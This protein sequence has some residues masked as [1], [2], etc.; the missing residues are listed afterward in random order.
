VVAEVNR[1]LAAGR[2]GLGVVAL[3]CQATAL[4]KMRTA[5][6]GVPTL[7]GGVTPAAGISLVVGL[8]CTWALEQEGWRRLVRQRLGT[9][10]FRR[11]DIPPPP[12][13]VLVAERPDGSRSEAPLAEV[14]A[15]VRP[16]CRVC[17][18]MTAENA[19]L[20]V[21]MAETAPGWNTL[22]VRTPAG[23]DLVLRA[24]AA[25]ALELRSVSVEGM[26]HLEAAS[27]GKKRRASE[28]ARTRLSAGDDPGA[29]ASPYLARVASWEGVA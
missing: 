13:E 16:G 24:V 23:E 12:A 5:G 19:D 26:A 2:D 6:S 1:A 14:R 28:E 27:L 3:P 29:A 9:G 7:P 17:M 22:L 25:G 21:G 18:D 10:P 15:L 11:V 4:V 8:F 20:S